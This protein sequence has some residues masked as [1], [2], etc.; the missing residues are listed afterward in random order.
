MIDSSPKVGFHIE[1]STSRQL[2]LAE[3]ISLIISDKGLTLEMWLEAA[4]IASH[5]CNNKAQARNA[6]KLMQC[7]MNTEKAND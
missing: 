3:T 5:V 2:L 7:V 6:L 4:D 1:A